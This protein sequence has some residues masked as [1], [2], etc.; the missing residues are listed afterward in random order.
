MRPDPTAPSGK[1]NEYK[2]RPVLP[3]PDGVDKATKYGMQRPPS[4]RKA[5]DSAWEAAEEQPVHHEVV[6]PAEDPFGKKPLDIPEIRDA[7]DPKALELAATLASRETLL[8]A[9]VEATVVKVEKKLYLCSVPGTSAQ[10][11]LPRDEKAG[12][13]VGSVVR[14][15]VKAIAPVVGTLKL[16][17]RGVK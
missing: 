5:S 7:V 10:G 4:S 3:S 2:E 14:V 8:D 12:L 9:I 17:A 6:K 15:R 13:E 16:T 1:R 11:Q